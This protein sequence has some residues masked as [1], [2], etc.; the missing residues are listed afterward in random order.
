MNNIKE[1][2]QITFEECVNAI[3]NSSIGK[4]ILHF[5]KGKVAN[6]IE[7]NTSLDFKIKIDEYE[8]TYIGR[9]ETIVI[10]NN[11]PTIKRSTVKIYPNMGTSPFFGEPPF[12]IITKDNFKRINTNAFN[13]LLKFTSTYLQMKNLDDEL[14]NNKTSNKI[15]KSKI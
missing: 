5:S 14:S 8:F 15:N 11:N 4:E 6:S 10:S 1:F 2:E 7:T 13:A 9:S 3:T 12:V